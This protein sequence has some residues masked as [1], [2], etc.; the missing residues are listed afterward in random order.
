VREALA[1]GQFKPN[2]AMVMI[3]FLI[4]HGILTVENEGNYLEILSRLHRRLEFPVET[5]VR[6]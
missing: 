1:E 3:D 6:D 5:C 2:C 4:R